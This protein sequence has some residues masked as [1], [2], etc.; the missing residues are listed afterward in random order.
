MIK[1]FIVDD[2]I[3]FREGLKR[4]IAGTSDI[5]LAGECGDGRK[6]LHAILKNEYDLVLL[7]LALPGMDGLEVLRALKREK[8]DLPVLVLSM[9]A[10]EQY[11][12]RVLQEGASGYLT[13]ESV[14][15]D[16]ISAIRKAA[17]GGRY[18]S[19]S[20]GEKLFGK[21]TGENENPPH[22]SL[23]N[24]EYQVFHMISKGQSIK[25]I[26]YDLKLA[27]TTVTSYRSR[28]LEK[29]KMTTNADLVR[30]AVENHLL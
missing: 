26:A 6:A 25:A 27:R 1:L 23:S 14:P 19:S 4:V 16:L 11:A 15:N 10:E 13:K 8:S 17:A 18:I 5:D 21:L 29:M 2:H 9:Y 22:E 20:L 30:Y 28:I 24:R 12:V 7:D 3:I